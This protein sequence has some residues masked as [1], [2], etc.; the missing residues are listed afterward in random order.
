[1]FHN[2]GDG[3]FTD[4]TRRLGNRGGLLYDRGRLGRLRQR[5]LSRSIRGR[6]L[7]PRK[8]IPTTFYARNGEPNQL[9]HNNGDGTF[10]NVTQQAGVGEHGL[11]L[12]V[13]WGDYNDDGYPD[14]YVVNDFGR[15][16]LYRNNRNGTFT[17]VTVKSR[18]LAYG[19]GMSASFVDYDNDG[20]PLRTCKS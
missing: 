2:N 19:A 8:D 15:K 1:M 5:W 9:Y 4:V 10:T 20:M 18:T 6:Y 7:D 12:G 17:D 14:L 13:V 3:T 16:T 11:C